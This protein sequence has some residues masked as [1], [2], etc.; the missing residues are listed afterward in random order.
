MSK[1][2]LGFS[3]LALLLS[4]AAPT[5]AA[6]QGAAFVSGQGSDAAGCGSQT[7]PC[8]TFQ[9]AHDKALGAA[10]GVI[11]V[12]DPAN[13][14]ALTITKPLAV[15]ND[16]VGTAG[17][18]AGPGGTAITINAGPSD[19]VTLRG[20]TLEGLGSA[21]TGIAFNS[22]GKIEIE[23][24]VIRNFTQ[25]GIIMIGSAF[26]Y[27]IS[28]TTVSA[29]PYNGAGGAILVY[30]EGS[31]VG[32]LENVDVSGNGGLGLSLSATNA[33]VLNSKISNNGGYGMQCDG[34]ANVS[35]VNTTINYNSVGV[36]VMCNVVLSRNTI[37]YN[38]IGLA[39]GVVGN[40]SMSS[41][42]DNDINFNALQ[43]GGGSLIP[44][45]KQ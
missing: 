42:G 24:S 17:M 10:G 9:F 36:N 26:S 37:Q 11:V 13:Y 39:L 4:A 41:Y 20:L 43:V 21:S 5:L 27:S 34:A 7:S 44:V 31:V 33:T 1:S 22:G 6:S 23:K 2:V 16:G 29:L 28:D 25:T 19:V 30:G 15:L 32:T 38:Q 8:R 3:A 35:I 18:G 12:H 14:G 40:G 45:A